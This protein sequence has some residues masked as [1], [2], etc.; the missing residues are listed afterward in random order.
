[1]GESAVLVA[2]ICRCGLVAERQLPKLEGRVRSP[3]PAPWPRIARGR[4]SSFL[5]IAGGPERREV[6]R[7]G[8]VASPGGVPKIRDMR[9]KIR[10]ISFPLNKEKSGYGREVL[11]EARPQHSGRQPVRIRSRSPAVAAGHRHRPR[12]KEDKP[13]P[14][15]EAPLCGPGGSPVGHLVRNGGQVPTVAAVPPDDSVSMG[16]ATSARRASSR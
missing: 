3:S 9:Y 12:G 15:K 6:S 1:M 8:V 4:I 13:R 2:A 14:V 5:C 11:W 7:G 10:D 16:I